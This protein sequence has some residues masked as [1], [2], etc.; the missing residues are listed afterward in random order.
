MKHILIFI[1]ALSL[2]VAGTVSCS[3]EGGDSPELNIIFDTDMGN[4][5]DDAL[6]LDMLYKYMDAGK[7]DLK[8]IM[9][10]KEGYAGP[11]FLD[12]MGTWYGYPDIPVGIIRDGAECGGDSTVFTRKVIDMKMADGEPV[13]ARSHGSYPEYQE[14]SVMYRE[15]LAGAADGS[16]TVIATG[17][18]TNLARLLDSGADKYSE[19]AGKEL[20]RRKV[21]TLYMMAG[22]MDDTSHCEYNIVKDISS[23]R[24]VFSEWP[25][26]IVVAPFELGAA[27]CYPA[28]SIMHDFGWASFHPAVE[29]YKAF[30]PMPY[31]R[32]SWDLTAVLAA[33]E[34]CREY[35][36]VSSEGS[37]EVTAG[38]A[39]IFREGEGDRVYL[40]A[41]RSQAEKIKERLISLITAVPARYAE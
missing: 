34:N 3:M 39:T 4:D 27:I 5:V 7:I 29:A 13:F 33:V 38:G 25:T 1:M 26:P 41:S 14:S 23:A 32:P 2:S 17:F 8:A 9:L 10:D 30:L 28:S 11:E 20:V 21:K 35:F 40:S 18:S 16:V 12:I 15:I 22:C 24:K 6:A 37:V 31:D 19:L 36:T